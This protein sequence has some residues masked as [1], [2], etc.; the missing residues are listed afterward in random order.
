MSDNHTL[1]PDPQDDDHRPALAAGTMVDHFRIMRLL[2]K[3]GMGA[4]YLARDTKLGRKIALKLLRTASLGSPKAVELFLHEAQ[5]TARF[6]H[7]HIVTIYAVGSGGPRDEPYVALEYLEGQTLRERMTADPPTVGETLRITLAIAQALDEAHRNTILHRDLKPENVMLPHDG[8][9]RVLD[10]GL[11]KTFGAPPK[12]VALD[13]TLP[14]D[15]ATLDLLAPPLQEHDGQMAGTPRYMA[16]EQWLGQE[17]SGATDIWAFG[18]ILYELISGKHPYGDATYLR[19][20]METSSEATAPSLPNTE[21][22]PEALH[23]LT[24]DCLRKK[25]DERPTTDEIVRILG[26]LL[27]RG[28]RP[29]DSETNPFR[30]L[31]TFGPEHADVFFGR[32]TELSAFLERLRHEPVLPVIGPSG[33]GKSSFVQAGVIPRLI[34]QRRLIVLQLRPGREPART[35]AARLATPRPATTAGTLS[36]S[37]H[38]ILQ[39]SQTSSVLARDIDAEKQMATELLG[40]PGRLALA[41]RELAE[42]EGAL[43]LL[44]V[45]QLEELY[46]LGDNAETQ[47]AFLQAVCGAADDPDDPVRVI[48][49][50]RDDFLGRLKG[51]V[52]VREAL[53][54]V[55][56][57]QPPGAE[58]LREIVT[59]PARGRGYRYDD[60]NL[61]DEMIAAVDGELSALPLLQF[62]C[63]LLWERRDRQKRLLL[64]QVHDELGGV[65]GALARHA[66]SVLEAMSAGQASL[67]KTL[68]LRLV[69]P[70]GTREVLPRNELLGGLD[71]DAQEVLDRLI[72]A[73][74]V[75]QRRAHDND[76]A[77]IELTHGSLIKSWDRLARWIDESGEERALRAEI[78]QA[79]ELWDRRGAR[80]AE[81]WS[82]TAL[83]DA[84]RA[85]RRHDLEISPRADRFLTAGRQRRRYRTWRRRG[86]LALGFVL[87]AAIA[88]TFFIKERET[89]REKRRAEAERALANHQKHRAETNRARAELEGARTA[90]VR[91]N[92]LEARSK[93]RAALE[94]SPIRSHLAAALWAQ[95]RE[96]PRIWRRDLNAPIYAVDFSPDGRWIAAG[97][98]DHT[99]YLLATETRDRRVLR[100]HVDQVRALAFSPDGK[101]L[102]SGTWSGAIFVWNLDRGTHRELRGHTKVVRHLAF[103]PD[104]KRLASASWDGTCRLWPLD[105]QSPPLVLRN[106]HA[107]FSTLAYS[108]DGKSFATAIAEGPIQ[109]R[110]PQTGRVL[111]TLPGHRGGTTGLAFSPKGTRLASVGADAVIRLWDPQSHQQT[112]V[113]AGPTG[114]LHDVRFDPAG[115]HLVAAGTEGYLWIWQ[116][117]DGTRSTLRG[118]KGTV[119]SLALSPDGRSLA[120]GAIDNTVRLWHLRAQ[121]ASL[122]LTA[123]VWGVAFTPDSKTVVAGAR[124]HT[125]RRW[126]VQDGALLGMH[127]GH[128]DTIITVATSPDGKTLATGS[129]DRTVRLWQSATG[130][131][132]DTLLGHRADVFAVAFSPDGKRLASGSVDKTVRIW[133]LKTRRQ[134]RVIEDLSGG[135]WDIAFSPDGRL[136]AASTRGKL[137]HLFDAKTYTPRRI[138]RGHKAS[139]FGLAFAPD[140]K[141][142]YSASG[143][144]TLRRWSLPSG[145]NKI[146]ARIKGRFYFVAVHP[147]GRWIAVTASDGLPRLY[148]AEGG[149]VLRV[150]RGHRGEANYL[151]FS[152]NGKLLATSGDDGTVRLWTIPEGRPLW[153]AAGIVEDIKHGNH[154]L[155]FS[156]RAWRDLQ[157]NQATK[158]PN[159]PWRRAVEDARSLD[160][161]LHGKSLCLNRFDGHLELWDLASHRRLF[162]DQLGAISELLALKNACVVLAPDGVRYYIHDGSYR[163]LGKA[164]VLTR[165]GEGFLLARGDEV[166]RFNAQGKREHTYGGLDTSVTAMTRVDGQLLLGFANGS[167]ERGDESAARRSFPFERVPSSAVVHLTAG[168]PKTLVASFANGSVGLWSLDDGL[169][170]AHTTLHGPVRHLLLQSRH[171]YALSNLGDAHAID[172]S[173]FYI[174]PCDLLRAIWRE[175]PSTWEHGHP[176]L[177]RPPSK[178]RCA[179]GLP[180]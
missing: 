136:L 42:R 17:V 95:L 161:D 153:H 19:L 27:Q 82:D 129:G 5:T 51:G 178:H 30:G 15:D 3:G 109:L 142:L 61:V 86:S 56:V 99:I 151:S 9:L 67:A 144:G 130:A 96:D 44:F 110:D 28:R 169:R 36:R 66:D 26:D 101:R 80:S 107:R 38:E 159:A 147:T 6:S 35:L 59:E 123:P 174:A 124:D 100:G 60:D 143:D 81:A 23:D 33:A 155:F 158:P 65:G 46:T 173:P 157:T 71:D 72:G 148:P 63:Q 12:A 171:L 13:A 112:R 87:L 21:G 49:T 134:V 91:G 78:E 108:R 176:I 126:R 138:L 18:V 150:L 84:E 2:G 163:H 74:L 133:D 156:H 16:P 29:R 25:A 132:I 43:V 117:K 10:F 120:S 111:A 69:T 175:V 32:E 50:L 7:P 54:R 92:L 145:N 160:L 180:R 97:G 37:H 149:D 39:E 93:L 125:L 146:L 77:Q 172:L 22:V 103:S 70:E 116:L 135:V 75:T 14:A 11:A 154:P 34:E 57:L 167:I 177:R 52:E 104:G 1:P 137:I 48:F 115:A 131:A 166:A 90:Y 8:R 89:A 139:V 168:P 24:E 94:R 119:T 45:D 73:R 79:A 164:R 68:L 88:V 105:A 85:I 53:S 121:Q 58:A 76:D 127:G 170:L 179:R 98:Q 64:R 118:H 4:V 83:G 113:L 31:A 20:A 122:A 140:S 55:T 165:D 152:P 114:T 141:A 47:R 128:T 40:N 41:L 162:V 106:A 102:A 62:T